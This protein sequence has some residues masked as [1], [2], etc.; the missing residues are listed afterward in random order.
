MRDTPELLSFAAPP[1]TPPQIL[2]CDPTSAEAQSLAAF[3]ASHEAT[4]SLYFFQTSGSEGHAKWVGLSHAAL[5]SSAQAVNHHLEATANDRWLICLPLHHV[6]GFSILT[7]CQQSGATFFHDTEKWNPTRFAQLCAEQNITLTSLVPTQIFDLVQQKLEAPST[8]RAIVVGGGALN[9]QLGQQAQ[10]LGWPVLQSYGMTESA[11]QIATAPLAQLHQGFDPDSLEVL[12]HWH[13]TTES[14]H[15]LIIRGPAL[16]DGYA[17]FNH[18]TQTWNW[19]PLNGE[20]RT[21]DFVHL[22]HHGTRQFLQMLGRESAFIK[23]KGELINLAILQKKIDLL[24]PGAIICPLPDPRRETKLILVSENH[25]FTSAQIETAWQQYHADSP[26]TERLHQSV[27][28]TQIPR[29][30][31]GKINLPQLQRELQSL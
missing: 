9:C 22:W 14:D 20:L 12:P 5:V 23:I 10:T 11:S 28:I 15:R 7:R 1:P 8:L 26:P 21:R 31:L 16:A 30:D 29:T 17:I 4:R 3:A 6:G 24:L 13:L 27:S 19:Q 2:A 18:S 25:Q